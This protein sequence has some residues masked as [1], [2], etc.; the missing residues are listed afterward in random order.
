MKK[1]PKKQAPYEMTYQQLM[2]KYGLIPGQSV[3]VRDDSPNE[4]PLRG[5][6]IYI[7]LDPEDRK[8]QILSVSITCI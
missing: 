5:L 7:P 3:Y 1:A 8:V 6:I 4:V 2:D